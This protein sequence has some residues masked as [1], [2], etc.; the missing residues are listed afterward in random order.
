MRLRFT[1]D[2]SHTSFTY[3]KWYDILTIREY[4]N[5]NT[6]SANRI[7]RDFNEFDIDS[8]INEDKYFEA[9]LYNDGG[10]LEYVELCHF[11]VIEVFRSYVIDNVLK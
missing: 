5:T 9:S 7:I 4:K 1:E 10:E 3:G 8:F 2:S 11:N 6:F